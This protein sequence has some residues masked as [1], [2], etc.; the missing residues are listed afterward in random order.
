MPTAALAAL[1]PTLR[2]LGRIL[3]CR[4]NTVAHC[5]P[6]MHHASDRLSNHWSASQTCLP[7]PACH[8]WGSAPDRVWQIQPCHGSFYATVNDTHGAGYHIIMCVMPWFIMLGSLLHCL[9][10]LLHHVRSQHQQICLYP[11]FC[12]TLMALIVPHRQQPPSPFTPLCPQTNLCCKCAHAQANGVPTQSAHRLFL[13][14]RSF[15][16]GS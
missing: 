13:P 16:C 6:C 11:H 5:L 1:V 4:Y 8:S 15:V 9:T 3:S 2:A 12:H 10:T 14:L 7:L